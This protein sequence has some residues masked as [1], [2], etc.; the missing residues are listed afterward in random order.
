[1]IMAFPIVLLFGLL[2]LCGFYFVMRALFNPDYRRHQRTQYRH[3]RVVQSP[4]NHRSEGVLKAFGITILACLAFVAIY[5]VRATG[6]HRNVV[7]HLADSHN[8]SASHSGASNSVQVA[9][10][11][12]S[13]R[14]EIINKRNSPPINVILPPPVQPQAVA[15]LPEIQ[16][17]TNL[18]GESS[19]LMLVLLLS[20][21][22]LENGAE[23]LD[24]VQ[25]A[26]PAQIRDAYTLVPLPNTVT[27]AVP[28]N[29][30]KAFSLGQM[31][32]MVQTFAHLWPSS[33]ADTSDESAQI[34]ELA[35]QDVLPTWIENPPDGQMVVMSEFVA[36]NVPQE[37]ALRPAI[38]RALLTRADTRS[39]KRKASDVPVHKRMEVQ[40]TNQAMERSIRKR[41]VRTEVLTTPAGPAPM[42]R[43]YALV[44]FPE[45]LERRTAHV[46]QKS[47]QRNRLLAVCAT[48]VSGWLTLVFLAAAIRVWRSD[49]AF[50][51]LIV[52]PT[53]G[54]LTIPFAVGFTVLISMMMDGQIHR[55][56]ELVPPEH[57]V[58]STDFN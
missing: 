13:A 31:E 18:D 34:A 47:E 53:L 33:S 52:T 11:P 56:S 29:L 27:E 25:Q 44:E 19:K 50:R 28:G 39:P 17:E 46:V 15:E 4:Q 2:V 42:R 40:L 26:L 51:K 41:F 55:I 21:D 6:T 57:Y 43:T 35:H 7:V 5:F 8:E 45:E 20:H 9:D 14:V 24:A 37:D 23:I 36:E 22:A 32:A 38:T 58:I 49:S 12:H 48:V 1:M 16:A 54:L 10:S 3:A 30:H